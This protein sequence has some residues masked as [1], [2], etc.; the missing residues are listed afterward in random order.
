M[1][2]R[3]LL[4]LLGVGLLATSCSTL[5]SPALYQND[6]AYQPKPASF[7]KEVSATYI[8]AGLDAHSSKSYN[9]FIVSG[10]LNLSQGYVFN[11]FNF[12]YGGFASFGNYQSGGSVNSSDP[13]YFRDKY[14]GAVG[15]RASINAFVNNDRADF[16]FIGVE[17][18]FSHEFG[19]YAAYRNRTQNVAGYYIDPRV[20]LFTI[21]LTT[22]VI[23][24]IAITK[25][26]N[27]EFAAF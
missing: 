4:T 3:I 19:D 8:S 1:K 14:F 16:R 22:E 2:H 27:M 7:D 18:A 25:T 21:G 26:Y 20:D 13:N 23:F 9:D 24:T 11:N 15:G 6:I 5:Y 10:Q 12:A 17:T